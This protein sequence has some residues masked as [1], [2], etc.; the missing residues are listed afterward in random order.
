MHN[1]ISRGISL[2]HVAVV[3]GI[4]TVEIQSVALNQLH[5]TKGLDVVFFLKIIGFVAGHDDAVVVDA[6]ISGQQGS[7]W[8]FDLVHVKIIR[9]FNQDFFWCLCHKVLRE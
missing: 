5:V 3:F 4:F 1:G 8:S 7:I 2:F 9:M 6:D